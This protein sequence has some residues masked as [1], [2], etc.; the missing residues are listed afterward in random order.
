MPQE[1]QRDIRRK[2]HA[3]LRSCGRRHGES[4]PLDDALGDQLTDGSTSLGPANGGKGL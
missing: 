4:R 3:K 1:H 2:Y